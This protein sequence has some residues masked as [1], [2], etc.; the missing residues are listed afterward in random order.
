[1]ITP[2]SS[3]LTFA[4]DTSTNGNVDNVEKVIWDVESIGSTV[5]IIVQANKFTMP[6]TEQAFAVA[7][8]IQSL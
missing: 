8:H 7:W 4:N 6:N 2:V 3:Q 1:M 5:T